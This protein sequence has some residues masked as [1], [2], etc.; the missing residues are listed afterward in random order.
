MC[1]AY[2]FRDGFVRYYAGTV[3]TNPYAP[4]PYECRAEGTVA[5]IRACSERWSEAS[6]TVDAS[7]T[8]REVW[9][10]TEYEYQLTD[11]DFQADSGT[12][13]DVWFGYPLDGP[14]GCR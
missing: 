3:E 6:M 9:L 7:G 4:V 11:L 8:L 5:R 14:G 1:E 12:A 2:Y 13:L 10:G